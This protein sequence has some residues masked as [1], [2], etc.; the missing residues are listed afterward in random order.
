MRRQFKEAGR[1]ISVEAE[2]A[3]FEPSLGGSSLTFERRCK[4]RTISKNYARGAGVSL[5]LATHFLG[6]LRLGPASYLVKWARVTGT[7]TP[8]GEG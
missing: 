7:L 4:M 5:A 3:E 8:R 1:I 6:Y 2:G